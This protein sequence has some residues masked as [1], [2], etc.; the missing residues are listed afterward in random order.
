M[1]QKTLSFVCYTLQSAMRISGVYKE[2]GDLTR[3]PV[4]L[5]L[6]PRP[7][8]S[9]HNSGLKALQSRAGEH[10]ADC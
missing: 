3:H 2:T 7:A 6:E 9:K 10:R 5:S 8:D 1:T 4:F